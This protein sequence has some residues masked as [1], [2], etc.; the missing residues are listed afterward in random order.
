VTAFFAATIALVVDDIKKIVA[1]STCSQL[2]YM[3][4]ACGVSAYPAAMFHLVTHAHF[5]ALL[6]LAVGSVI[7][8]TEGEQNIKKM[9]GLRTKLPITYFATLVGSLSLSGIFPFSGFFSKD[10]ILEAAFLKGSISS[11]I[12]YYL[13]MAGVI[14][15]AFYSFRLFF[16]VFHGPVTKIKSIHESPKTMLIPMIFLMFTATFSG[17]IGEYVLRIMSHDLLFWHY[18]I[19][20]APVNNRLGQLHDIAQHI[21]IMPLIFASVAIG[22]AAMLY[23]YNN[24]VIA[25][26]RFICVPLHKLLINK[27]YFDEFYDLIFVQSFKKISAFTYQKID[28]KYIDG[29][30]PNGVARFVTRVSGCVRAI[31]NGLIYNYAF[32]MVVGVILILTWYVVRFVL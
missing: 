26:L 10:V 31:Q 6:F 9:G 4:I 7:H 5:K 12:A 20:I 22:A 17:V 32:A 15:T 14:L 21:K 29:C 25:K 8:A 24:K 1:Y 28:V 18:S 30:G 3:F 23:L 2:G 16:R 13:G 19:Y 27:Y 11:N